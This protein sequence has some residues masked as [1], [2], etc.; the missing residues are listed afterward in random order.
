M[1]TRQHGSQG[2]A[3]RVSVSV[4]C[5]VYGKCILCCENHHQRILLK[6]RW[7][8]RKRFYGW[9]V[10]E[11]ATPSNVNL[12]TFTPTLLGVAT[13]LA[14]DAD[15]CLKTVLTAEGDA[16]L[17]FMASNPRMPANP[18]T[19]KLYGP[20]RSTLPKERK[21]K[22]Q[23]SSSRQESDWRYLHKVLQKGA[24]KAKQKIRFWVLTLS[25]LFPDSLRVITVFKEKIGKGK[26]EKRKIS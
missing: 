24:S 15:A 9:Y 10:Y 8:R 7:I 5:G 20:T 12:V 13:K 26:C 4:S 2:R 6:W 23:C 1:L 22:N 25:A 16:C 19:N 21:K 14:A 18:R 11:R 17:F 3:Y